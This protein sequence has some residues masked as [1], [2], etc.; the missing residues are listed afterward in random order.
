MCR[1]VGD[2]FYLCD[3][4]C[5][6]Q[7]TAYEMRIRDWSSDVCSSDLAQRQAAQRQPRLRRGCRRRAHVEYPRRPGRAQRTP[8]VAEEVVEEA[9]DPVALEPR[10]AERRGGK[11][12]VSTC[13]SRCYP[14][15][16]NKK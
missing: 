6:K 13:K 12:C 11:E 2:V 7:K 4:F 8:P 1:S 14:Y 16:Y 9:G 3:F 15:H 10:S 5:F